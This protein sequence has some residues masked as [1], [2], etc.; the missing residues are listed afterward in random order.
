MRCLPIRDAAGLCRSCEKR[1]SMLQCQVS[2]AG[3]LYVLSLIYRH[4]KRHP[5]RCFRENWFL[6]FPHVQQS[7]SIWWSNDILAAKHGQTFD[8]CFHVFFGSH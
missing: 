3:F 4:G 6:P 1:R 8:G 7:H 5:D 2:F